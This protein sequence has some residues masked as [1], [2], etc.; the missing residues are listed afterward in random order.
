VAA[1]WLSALASGGCGRGV[2][3]IATT[4]VD[5]TYS[6]AEQAFAQLGIQRTKMS[7]EQEGASDRREISGASPDREVTVTLHSE[8]SGTKIQVVT[9]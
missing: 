8:G 5:R 3:S 6:A 9:G 7:A 4:S 2:E 1:L